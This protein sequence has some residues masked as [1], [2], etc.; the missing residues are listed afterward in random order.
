[1]L[2]TLLDRWDCIDVVLTATIQLRRHAVMVEVSATDVPHIPP[3][4]TGNDL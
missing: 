4:A 2:E 1:M 3:R